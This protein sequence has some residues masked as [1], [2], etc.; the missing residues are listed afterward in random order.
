[1]M[2][3]DELFMLWTMLY[4][5][6]VNICYYLLHYLV[7]I[8]KKKLDDKGDMV[9]GGIITFISRKFGGKFEQGDQYD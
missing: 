3:T 1:M 5:H 2:R 4:N 8:A 7:S 9:V 6:H